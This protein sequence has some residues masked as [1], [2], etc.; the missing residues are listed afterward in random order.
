[1]MTICG[2]IITICVFMPD[3]IVSICAGSERG[4][5]G[6]EGASAPAFGGPSLRYSPALNACEREEEMEL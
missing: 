3:I 5:G 6:A 4:F 1:M 2:T